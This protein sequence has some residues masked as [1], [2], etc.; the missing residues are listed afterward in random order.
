MTFLALAIDSAARSGFAVARSASV[1]DVAGAVTTAAQ[2]RAV[3]EDVVQRR[4][5][6]DLPLVVV[7]EDWPGLW[8]SWK[9]AVGAGRNWGRWLDHIE[10][11][12]GVREDQIV[13]V[14]TRR[15][16]SDLFGVELTRMKTPKGLK[17]RPP[18]EMKR[19]ACTYVGEKDHDQA[20]AMCLALW[21]HTSIDAQEA[22]DAAMRRTTRLQRGA[23][24]R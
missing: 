3:C 15:W 22:A 4:L 12:L 7:A 13:R 11:V 21:A 23:L 18:E 16:R 2:R 20:E 17:P 24:K 5:A 1:V 9:T 8:R 6:A 14:N 19:L 10:L